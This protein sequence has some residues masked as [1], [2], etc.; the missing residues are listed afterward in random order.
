M[1]NA[2]RFR[3]QR[4][5]FKPVVISGCGFWGGQEIE[6][7]LLPAPVNAGVVFVRTD[8]EAGIRI[9]ALLTSRIEASNRTNLYAAGACVEM[10]EHV[11]SAL[12]GLEVD[13]AFV[14]VTSAEMPG[15]DGSAKGFVAGIDS[16][17]IKDLDAPVNPIV[18]DQVIRVGD[19]AA[20]IEASPPQFPGLSIDYQLDYGEGPIGQQALSLC[21]TPQTYRENLASARTFISVADAEQ[22]RATGRGLAVNP[23]DLLVFGPEGPLDNHLRWPDECV[24]HKMLDVVGD[25]SLAGRP[26]HA[27]LRAYRS[28]HRLNA[29]LLAKLLTECQLR[30]CA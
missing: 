4:T 11:L 27:H 14:R 15:L 24:R 13:C 21:V 1:P 17:G 19:D 26:I 23:R 16:V 5:I 22:L 20:W 2:P 28:G 30:A 3:P 7:T 12:A 8:L 10:V 9:P 29:A 18:V 25:L 6:V